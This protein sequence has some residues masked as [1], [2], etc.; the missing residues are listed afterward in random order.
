V[1][2]GVGWSCPLAAFDIADGTVI[3]ELHRKHRATEH[4]KFLRAIDGRAD[5]TDAQWAVLG[6]L[7][8]AAAGG[9][10]ARRSPDEWQDLILGQL[11]KGAVDSGNTVSHPP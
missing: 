10:S 8:P 1:T 2:T 11:V 9:D 6:P 5:L 3:S 7:L 4:L